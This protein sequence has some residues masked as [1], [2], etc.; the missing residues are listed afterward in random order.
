MSYGPHRNDNRFL[1]T[2][3]LRIAPSGQC[4]FVGRDLEVCMDCAT[5]IT[6]LKAVETVKE[7]RF[8]HDGGRR[9]DCLECCDECR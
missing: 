1:C 9:N 7:L 6:C 5:C 2:E 8:M 3:C 4:V